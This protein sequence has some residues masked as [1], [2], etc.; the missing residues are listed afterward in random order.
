MFGLP[1]IAWKRF[2]VWLVIGLTFYFV[3]GW[4]RGRLERG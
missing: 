3:Y 1:T 4:R 2:G